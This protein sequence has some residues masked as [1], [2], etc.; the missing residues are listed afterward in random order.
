MV[1]YSTLNNIYYHTVV[2]SIAVYSNIIIKFIIHKLQSYLLLF[3]I[4]SMKALAV[5][6]AALS[7]WLLYFYKPDTDALKNQA[8]SAH[9]KMLELLVS[10]KLHPV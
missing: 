6:V 4:T 5:G 3:F 10:Q 8:Q 7:I 2:Y 9:E 1:I